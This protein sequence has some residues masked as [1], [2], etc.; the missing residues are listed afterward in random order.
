M[1]TRRLR[2][3][4]VPCLLAIGLLLAACGGSG[5]EE[6]GPP[7]LSKIFTATPPDPLPEAIIVG[8]APSGPQGNTYTIQPGD[9]LFAIAEQFSTTVEALMEANNIDDPT[10]LEV[11]QKLVIPGAGPEAEGEALGATP[12]PPSTPALNEDGTYTVQAGDSAY[13]IA[14]QFGTTVEELAA[15][16]ELTLEALLNLFPGDV[17]VIPSPAPGETPSP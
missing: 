9:S 3:A 14:A 11:G 16:N 15:A 5:G 2:V 6:T 17:L 8:E 12:E 1:N 4:A 10:Q 7:D 13:D